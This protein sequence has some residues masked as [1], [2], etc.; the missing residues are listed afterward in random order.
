MI[1]TRWAANLLAAAS[2]AIAAT[3]Y[4]FSPQEYSF[5]PRCPVY[6][7]THRFCPGCGATRA[8]AELLHGHVATALHFNAAVILLLPLGLCYFGKM[9]WTIV[10][11][12]RI[13]W[14]QI[15]QWSWQAVLAAV[16]LFTLARNLA[17]NTL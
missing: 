14:P 12:N 16:L 15:P 13:A 3:L 17:Q 10:K 9:Y 4:R 11:H 6:A 2:A 1:S 8:I 5:Y 7:L